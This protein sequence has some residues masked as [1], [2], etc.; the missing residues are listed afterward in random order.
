M[1]PDTHQ[2]LGSPQPETPQRSSSQARY[3]GHLR[4]GSFFAGGGW[5][6]S[7]PSITGCW[8]VSLGHP[9]KCASSI[10][11]P[12]AATTPNFLHITHTPS[13]LEKR[14]ALGENHSLKRTGSV[15]RAEYCSLQYHAQKHHQPAS[16]I[17][18]AA[19][20]LGQKPKVELCIHN[21]R[22]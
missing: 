2:L 8:A 13:E 10:P 3:C 9:T 7:C 14:T 11:C 15:H 4:P 5:G 17:W 16:G 18:K 22:R 1:P 6:P 20:A 21:G 12:R 19:F